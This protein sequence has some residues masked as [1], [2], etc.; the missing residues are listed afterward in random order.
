MMN[1]EYLQRFIL[2]EFELIRFSISSLD[3]AMILTFEKIIIIY[4]NYSSAYILPH[5]S[6][7]SLFLFKEDWIEIF[8][9]FNL[10]DSHSR[11]RI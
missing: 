1:C 3:K 11:N 5:C 6:F 7:P 8:E 4:N 10:T 9:T 2:S